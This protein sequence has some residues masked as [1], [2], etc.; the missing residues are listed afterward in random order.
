MANR[1]WSWD[2]ETS[3]WGVELD[4]AAGVLHWW[5][6]DKPLPN[7][8]AYAQGGG[9]LDQTIVELLAT[10]RGAYWCPPEILADV[11]AEAERVT[12]SRGS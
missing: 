11:I 7:V 8:P 10:R 4:A 2:T 1:I 9:G 3:D 12:A 6:S 5:G